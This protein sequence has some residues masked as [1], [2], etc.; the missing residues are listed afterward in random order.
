MKKGY[1]A[2]VP[3]SITPSRR[4]EWIH[5]FNEIL[6]ST[7]HFSR[8]KLTEH[9]LTLGIQSYNQGSKIEDTMKTQD[10]LQHGAD[11]ITLQGDNL[12][13]EQKQ[14]LKTSYFQDLL[15]SFVVNLFQTME[16]TTVEFARTNS[17]ESE[18][19]QPV[20]RNEALAET[21]ITVDKTIEPGMQ[22]EE[23]EYVTEVGSERSV[24]S[25][26]SELEKDAAPEIETRENNRPLPP[27]HTGATKKADMM[28]ALQMVK[29]MNMRQE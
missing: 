21:A 11:Q 20:F 10:S 1:E 22:P 17:V 4:S 13:N 7:Q 23:V 24:E 28:K 15:E 29:G 8:N 14:L 25:L 6:N 26:V 3:A 27:S 5:D 19:V 2:G 9:L 18:P 16:Q 12:S